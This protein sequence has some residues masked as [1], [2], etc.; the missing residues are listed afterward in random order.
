M[1]ALSTRTAT[2]ARRGLAAGLEELL[3]LDPEGLVL[4][5]SGEAGAM[6]RVAALVRAANIPV[7]GIQAPLAGSGGKPQPRLDAAERRDRRA[8]FEA[9]IETVD[10]LARVRGR[11]LLLGL[12]DGDLSGAEEMRRGWSEGRLGAAELAEWRAERSGVRAAAVERSCRVLHE[13]LRRAGGAQLVLVPESDPVG[14]LDAETAGWMLEDLGGAGLGIAWDLGVLGLRDHRGIEPLAGWFAKTAAQARMILIADHDGRE[15]A[16][17][18]PGAGLLEF[19][20]LQSELGRTIP[21]VLRPDPEAGIAEIRESAAL[22]RDRL[23]PHPDV[24]RE[25]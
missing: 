5:T 22:I 15:R 18:L 1:I 2:T 21:W 17:L 7:L 19:A 4:E 14:L 13:L 9:V 12:G 8:A 3:P 10:L 20:A 16:D 23:G 11:R 24:G 6:D 25:A